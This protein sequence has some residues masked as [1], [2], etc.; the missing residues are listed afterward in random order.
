M[1]RRM[2]NRNVSVLTEISN[3]FRV[4]GSFPIKGQDTAARS[5]PA[6]PILPNS[7]FKK[8]PY[9]S[10]LTWL[11]WD[12]NPMFGYSFEKHIRQNVV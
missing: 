7:N 8:V 1:F 4:V 2:S 12:M 6:F 5:T 10:H 9:S 3:A 11:V